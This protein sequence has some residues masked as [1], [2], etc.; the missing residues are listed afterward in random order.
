MRPKQTCICLTHS[1]YEKSENIR[2][3]AKTKPQSIFYHGSAICNKL[4]NR[5]TCRCS[6]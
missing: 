3:F 1:V 4:W 2:V 6:L 5:P